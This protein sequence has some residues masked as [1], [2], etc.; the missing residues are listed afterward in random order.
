M[1]PRCPAPATTA[2]PQIIS[3][4]FVS[5]A[6]LE[7]VFKALGAV[8]VYGII[9]YIVM[10]FFPKQGQA[11][12]DGDGSSTTQDPTTTAAPAASF[13]A[14]AAHNDTSHNNSDVSTAI[15]SALAARGT[16][17]AVLSRL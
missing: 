10:R 1:P 6:F 9:I 7:G 15:T 8:T 14:P 13:F 4:G 2:G 5:A 12:D 16:V 17:P 3:L 11:G